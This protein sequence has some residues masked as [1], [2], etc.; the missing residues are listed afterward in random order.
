MKQ[1]LIKGP[2]KGVSGTV[3]IEGA[4]NSCLVLMASS[5]LFEGKVTFTN[6]PLVKDVL[7]MVK[8]LSAINSKV[9]ISEKKKNG[10]HNK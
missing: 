5:I 9:I 10:Y 3:D 7:T 8:L 1:Y 2:N 6:V 4:K